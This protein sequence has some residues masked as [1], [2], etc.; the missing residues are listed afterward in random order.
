MWYSVSKEKYL[1]FLSKLNFKY[2]LSLAEVK[3]NEKYVGTLWYVEKERMSGSFTV[4]TWINRVDVNPKN[5]TQFSVSGKNYFRIWEFDIGNR[6]FEM[7]KESISVFQQLEQ[8][9]IIDHCWIPET[10]M[11][12]AA[13]ADNIIYIYSTTEMLVKYNFEYIPSE[14]KNDEE[15]EKDNDALEGLDDHSKENKKE[16]AGYSIDCIEPTSKCL[17][18]GLKNIPAICI[19][20]LDKNNQVVSLGSFR[21]REE[22]VTD[23][24]SVSTSADDLYLGVS[25]LSSIKTVNIDDGEKASAKKVSVLSKFINGLAQAQEE[26]KK[27]LDLFIFNK[28]VVDAVKSVQRDPFEPIFDKGVHSGMIKTIALCPSKTLLA[29]LADDNTIKFWEYGN[30][31]R[32]LYSC[33]FHDKPECV[34]IH[35]LAIQVAIGF[36]EG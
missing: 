36:G 12:A 33:F 24:N 1:N 6:S 35:P 14:I 25:A 10:G 4:P 27:K 23:I 13:T 30:E 34:A 28:A 3:K 9:H 18:L 22:N 19:F 16:P 8:E 7:N 15:G 11:I 2:L 29:S 21:T 31:Y 5:S 32:E 20:E 26:V 17:V